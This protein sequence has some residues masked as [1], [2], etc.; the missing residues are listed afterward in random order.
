MLAPIKKRTHAYSPSF[1][2]QHTAW[3]DFRDQMTIQRKV[4][5]S[6]SVIEKNSLGRTGENEGEILKEK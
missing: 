5:P 1:V 2:V 3:E 6:F 4:D